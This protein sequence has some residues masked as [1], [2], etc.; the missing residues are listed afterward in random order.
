M[1]QSSTDLYVAGEPGEQTR[2]RA[3]HCTGCGRQSFPAREHCPACGA[4]SDA[5]TL[6]GPARLRVLTGV[7]AQPPGSLVAAPYDVGVAEF[8]GGLC[9]IGLV[10][11]PAELGDQVLPVVA[12]P[13]EGGRIFGF[14]R[15]D[16][17]S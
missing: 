3:S 13:Y 14:R 7:H 4:D 8:D 6:A 9:V 2:L 10:V 15:A 17:W 11:G 16:G 1:T 12:E 5:I